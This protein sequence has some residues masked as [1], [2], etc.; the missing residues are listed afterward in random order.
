MTIQQQKDAARRIANMFARGILKNVNNGA[1]K[2]VQASLMAGETQDS[3][4]FNQPFGFFSSPPIES[5]LLVGFLG[6]NRDAGS[7]LH[8]HHAPSVPTDL[9]PGEVQINNANITA[10]AKIDKDGNITINA[11]KITLNFNELEINGVSSTI[12]GQVNGVD[13]T[14]FQNGA[15][16]LITG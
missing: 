1:N 2:T 14:A 11:N 3:L 12:T 13:Y 7:V 16:S 6:G 15:I 5:N 9:E 4:E 10:W 8:A